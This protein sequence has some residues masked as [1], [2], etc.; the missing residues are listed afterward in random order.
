MTPRRVVVLVADLF[1]SARIR[2]TA[3]SLGV[4]LE[5]ADAVSAL[6]TCRARPP[7]LVIMDLHAGGDPLA[8]A[9]SLKAEPETRAIPI[10]GFYSHVDRALR[11]A[12][13]EAGMD[14]VLPRSA[15]TAKLP[16]LLAATAPGDPG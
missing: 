10:V 1:F 12:A 11:Q 14:H 3:G 9:R 5:E 4:A 2:A 13:L 15:F 8:V 6:E 16:E 7:G